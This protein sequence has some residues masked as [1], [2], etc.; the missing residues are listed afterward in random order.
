MARKILDEDGVTEIEV[1]SADEV[2]TQTEAA[3]KAKET[4]FGTIKTDLETKLGDATKAL[5]ER[6]GEFK[7]FR[8]LNDDVVAKLSTAERTIYENGLLLQKANDDRAESD[9]KF[10]EK[11]IDSIIRA[12]VG[13]DEKL[14]GKVKEMYA[15]IGIQ[16][17]TPEE[18]E[19][20]TLA[21]IGA[22]GTTSPDLVASVLGINGSYKPPEVKKT[23]DS[24]A[25]T[26]KGKAGAAELGL[27]LE[28]PV[29]K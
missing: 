3:V 24:F 20:K 23:D 19:R 7:Q 14:F 13:T 16:A 12:K 5:S 1:Y 4:E 25:N 15:V 21:A 28:P 17:V 27:I 8:K 11:T 26:D 9:K 2:K 22:L 10:Q 29:K 18:I 6:T